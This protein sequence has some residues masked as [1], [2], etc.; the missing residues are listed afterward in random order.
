MN[1]VARS[2][3]VAE[4]VS[5]P[6]VSLPRSEFSRIRLRSGF[7]RLVVV[8]G[9]LLGATP[10]PA[11]V[12][13]SVLQAESQR[14]AVM[15]KA[16][17]AAIAIFANGGQGGG[18]GVVISPDGYALSN[19][20]VT[21]PAGDAMK[22]G[23]AHGALYDA[24]I[25]GIDPV[26]D[27]ALLKLFGRDDFPHAELGDSDQ[28][29]VGDWAFAV[30]NPFLLATDFQPTVTYGII[31]GVHRYQY[32]SGTLLEYADCLQTD[33]SI[34]PGNSGGP[35]FDSQ[36]R[37]IGING[38]GS[39][40]KRG[41]VNVGVGYAISINQIKNFLGC[42]RA[43]RIVDHATLGA[44][45]ASQ[46]DG[47]VIVADIV[48]SSDAY[49]RGLRYGDEIVSFGGRPIRTVNAFKNVLGIF[50]KGWRVPVVFRRKGQT[51]ETLVRLAGVHGTEELLQKLGGKS[52]DPDQPPPPQPGDQPPDGQPRPMPMPPSA[53]PN[54]PP[55]PEIVQQHLEPR[56]GYANYYFNKLNRGRVWNQLVARGDFAEFAG[57]WR[58]KGEWLGAGEAEFGISSDGAM[59]AL[60][61]GM[62]TLTA[63]DSLSDAT[64]P[65]ASGGLLAALYL[66]RRLLV[67]GPDQ[68]GSLDYF[69]TAPFIGHDVP[70][71][72]EDLLDVLI[73]TSGG[74]EC[75]FVVD[76]ASGRLLLLEVFLRSD[77][78]PCE[79]YFF[80]YRE[81]EGRE[82][83]GKLEVRYGDGLYGVF[84]LTD[85]TLH[86]T[87]E[88]AP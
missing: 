34:N 62:L 71:R 35:L 29:R 70:G 82:L 75:Q 18:S 61:G 76:P 15:A 88:D 8:F 2:I 85:W 87:A 51:F 3:P 17:E 43:G 77:D 74:V 68:F 80:D 30:G 4:L 41:R 48:E 33:A 5:V 49:R 42:L 37:L 39:F 6:T 32:P 12:H 24:V 67:G 53:M 27:L 57:P 69:G 72:Q 45:V 16:R 63:G 52:P 28:V 22:C 56:R 36:G 38:R 1:G 84:K 11:Q 46:D 79:L 50:P 73:G 44:R 78:D 25:V 60:P 47:R 20:H 86:K 23:M 26:G 81:H 14:V 31:S 19:F 55:L 10:S 9:A 65:P 21:K 7:L 13:E 58:V 59:C 40:E 66:W 54:A 64:D 83:P